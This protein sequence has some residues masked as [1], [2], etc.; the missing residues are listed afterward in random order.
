MTTVRKIIHVDM[1]AFYASIE[2][3]DNPGLRGKPVAVGRAEE[4]GV[5][6]AASYEARR[7]GVHSAMSSRRAAWLCPGLIFVEP[8]FGVYKEVSNRIHDI[9]HE[10]TDVVEPLAL[11]E[12]FLDVTENK[13]GMEWAVDV[14]RAIKR[15]IREGL[16]LVA[17]A[18]V[19]YNKF[20]AKVASDYRKP[21]G[22]YVVH[23]DRAEGFIAGLPIEAFWGV[24]EVTARKMHG[25]GVHTG[26][27]LRGCS[28]EFL[29]RNFGKA[30]KLFYDFARGVDPRPVMP[31][32]VRK[33]VGCETTFERD[34]GTR[35]GLIIELYHVVVELE[36]R[37]GK[38]G[39]R[40]QTLTLKVRYGDFSQHTRSVTVDH[41]LVSRQEILPLAKGLLAELGEELA[42]VR[43]LG[44]SVSNPVAPLAYRKPRQLRFDF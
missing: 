21:D 20:L 36:R 38:S 3:R 28:L 4:R 41:P 12:A 19:S 44:V 22:L 9:F 16:G 1:D 6:A 11:D 15:E 13:A 17:S 10:Y 5:V 23:P 25:L 2:Q 33:S 32:R 30:G 8:R 42:P 27:E 31:E 29:Y 35:M 37:L 24:G 26:R 14:A 18:G 40:G 7:Y 39:F 34:V 43:L